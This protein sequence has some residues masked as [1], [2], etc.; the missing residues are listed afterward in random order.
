MCEQRA[1]E[2]E[3]RLSRTVFRSPFLLHQTGGWA[4]LM[5]SM[6]GGWWM[7]LGVHVSKRPGAM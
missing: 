6:Q 1:K 4:V 2:P 7:R 3:P 5:H